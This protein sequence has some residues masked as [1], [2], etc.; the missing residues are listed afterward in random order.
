MNKYIS[1]FIL[2]ILLC[3]IFL[4]G[5]FAQE[6]NRTAGTGFVVNAE[7]YIATCYHVVAQTRSISVVLTDSNGLR[8]SWNAVIYAVDSHSD[9]AILK[10][11]PD[12]KID[13]KNKD[14][15]A[16][17]FPSGVE[18]N[19]GKAQIG[20]EAMVIGYPLLDA[21][22]QSVKMSKGMVSGFVNDYLQVDASI[23]PG[24]S[25][26]PTLD[27]A[28]RAFGIASAKLAG[29]EV[30]NVGIC[31]PAAK[32]IRLLETNGIAYTKS[33]ESREKLAPT[34]IFKKA[35]LSVALILVEK[36][37]APTESDSAASSQQPFSTPRR[38]LDLSA[39][40]DG[41]IV[42]NGK[43]AV[44][45]DEVHKSDLLPGQA[46]LAPRFYS[47]R[48]YSQQARKCAALAFGI[49]AAQAQKDVNNQYEKQI[50]E[51][52]S[53][54]KKS[55]LADFLTREAAGEINP[56]RQFALYNTARLTAVQSGAVKQVRLIVNAMTEIWNFD[57]FTAQYSSLM[58]VGPNLR[59]TEQWRD[60]GLWA[61]ELQ[62]AAEKRHSVKQAKALQ[63]IID[64]ARKKS[65]D[66][67][68]EIIAFS[69]KI[70]Q[71][72]IA[73]APNVIMLT[74]SQ[75]NRKKC[76]ILDYVSQMV[77]SGCIVRSPMAGNTFNGVQTDSSLSE[78]GMVIG[79]EITFNQ[80]KGV[81]SLTP[82]Y[83]VKINGRKEFVRGKTVG[84]PGL[85]PSQVLA[86]E[87]YAVSGI[88]IVGSNQLEGCG[89]IQLKFS[90]IND[91][92]LLNEDSYLSYF[93]GRGDSNQAS[94][95][96]A[97]GGMIVG[98]QGRVSEPDARQL[99]GLGVLVVP[100][101]E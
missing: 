8:Q 92:G 98:L 13:P 29:P 45:P 9:L 39:Y 50:K 40:T 97:N 74:S 52:D 26:G 22:G 73:S 54:E 16:A 70:R 82:L 34:E 72:G 21:L 89:G 90:R 61:V 84:S 81:S 63:K 91:F 79:M 37:D 62:Y 100:Q 80:N 28:G 53:P 76:D 33:D 55:S 96:S 47:T 12:D 7:G 5:S 44:A 60:L 83:R 46:W 101:G 75:V 3:T 85:A 19:P 86:R 65:P 57:E 2:P 25:G 11:R 31:V 94:I 87:G 14:N 51:A 41:A 56:A 27:N 59:S 68:A 20:Q 38:A 1:F 66:R 15:Q 93:V 58:D 88:K 67:G 23:N 6:R 95:F 32:L 99:L 48:S 78:G 71:E 18:I 35:Y 4:S 30:S 24:N 43:I 10:I 69:V 64:A 42:F 36:L 17:E 77:K 49:E